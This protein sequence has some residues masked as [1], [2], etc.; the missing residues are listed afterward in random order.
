MSGVEYVLTVATA[1]AAATVAGAFFTFSTFT[2]AGLR[3]LQPAQGAAAMQAINKEAPT[4]AFMLL[5]FGT[6]VAC[7][8]LMVLAARDLADP[9]ATYWL[10][11]GAVYLL[12]VV[13]MTI[14]YHVPRNN[15]L[16]AVDP[17]SDQGVAYWAV[18]VKEW[19]RMNHV[20]TLAPIVS[21]VLLV[22]SLG[23]AD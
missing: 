2:M 19:G 1:V 8:V 17:Q 22:L 9:Q 5:L 12:G 15:R 18:Y 16:D 7:V 20:R 3:R 11:A 13:I 6:G 4:P 10:V 23:V 21:A 14:G